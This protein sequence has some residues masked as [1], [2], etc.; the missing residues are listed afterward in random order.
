VLD[1]SRPRKLRTTPPRIASHRLD[2][3]GAFDRP[4]KLC[5]YLTAANLDSERIQ[6]AHAC[7]FTPVYR[8]AAIGSG[9][10]AQQLVDLGCEMPSMLIGVLTG[11][12]IEE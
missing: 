6:C 5:H 10:L 1:A 12:E 11:L 2:F 3:I 9:M 7:Y 4:G 8:K